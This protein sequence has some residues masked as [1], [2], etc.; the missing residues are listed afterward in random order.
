MIY[1]C[2]SGGSR[3]N[4]K[5]RLNKLRNELLEKPS[6]TQI[7]TETTIER[8]K[9]SEEEKRKMAN[10][11][12]G[13]KEG[14]VSPASKATADYFTKIINVN[15]DVKVDKFIGWYFNNMV[16]GNY[17][18]IG[19]LRMPNDM[20]NSIEKMAVWYELRYP[21]YEINR[22]MPGSSQGPIEINDVM[23]NS[24]KYINELFDDNADVR[25]LDWAEFYNAES[26]LNSL[27]LA[28]RRLFEKMAYR[29]LVYIDSH[30]SN[31][32]L[33]LTSRGIVELSEEIESYTDSKVKDDEL[34]G[35]HIKDVVNL[36]KE[37]GISLPS[38]NELEKIIKVVENR[39]YQTEEMLNCV[40]YRIIERGGNRIGPRRAFLFAKEFGRNIDIPMMYGV[41]YSDPG[42][43]RFVIDY[44]KAGG[45]KDLECYIGYFSRSS[46]S[47]EMDTVTV[48]E[49]LRTHHNNYVSKYTPEEI[50]LHQRLVNA[51][52][53]QIDQSEVRKEKTKQLRL[54]RRLN[55]S[56]NI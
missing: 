42:L 1:L 55:K 13:F 27:S 28:E 19:E 46:R 37:R 47:E 41:D 38:D 30:C 24:N 39:N 51:L 32:C 56:K 5:E 3:M 17:T 26:F 35:M 18:G 29:P 52:A 25:S 14:D 12:R 45:S 23:F 34:R 2:I 33:H 22:L 31:V 15:L 21:D 48:G 49:M 40:M 20:R 36:L 8:S 7:S 6:K 16:R 10:N 11:Y 44:I 43:R 54:Q 50:V 4:L 9:D 53:S